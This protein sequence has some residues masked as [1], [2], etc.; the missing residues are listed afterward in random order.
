MA[1]IMKSRVPGRSR[2]INTKYRV[3]NPLASYAFVVTQVKICRVSRGVVRDLVGW[4]FI[5][6]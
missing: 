1:I 3:R 4:P 6:S 5:L 2:N